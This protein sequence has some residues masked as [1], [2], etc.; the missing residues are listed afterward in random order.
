MK[1]YPPD[2]LEKTRESQNTLLL[3]EFDHL[4][5]NSLTASEIQSNIDEICMEVDTLESILLSEIKVH[6][7]FY[8]TVTVQTNLGPCDLIVYKTITLQIFPEESIPTKLTKIMS[9][10][11]ES[12][13]TDDT[14]IKEEKK[15][16]VKI[17]NITN[18]PSFTVKVMLPVS[19]PS[20]TPPIIELPA[21]DLFKKWE[22]VIMPEFQKIYDSEGSTCV[23]EWY[24]YLHCEFVAHF[25]ER[26]N[27]DSLSLTVTSKKSYEELQRKSR[28]TL[29][30]QLGRRAHCCMICFNHFY[31]SSLFVIANCEHFFCK[32]CLKFYC[33]NLISQGKVNEIKCPELKCG[34]T[35]SDSDLELIVS[36]EFYKK[37]FKFRFANEID[38]AE[39][40]TWCPEENCDGVARIVGGNLFG[41]C[42]K[43]Y[44]RFCLS[45]NHFYHSGRRCPVLSLGR[46]QF[47]KMTKKQQEEFLKEK[48][49][50]FYVLKHCK[51]CPNCHA[52]ISKISGC[53]KMVCRECGIYFCWKCLSIIK[54]YDHFNLN[55]DCWD[56]TDTDVGYLTNKEV[57]EVKETIDD[58][59]MENSVKCPH[60]DRVVE[61]T[62]SSNYLRCSACFTHLC[63]YCGNMAEKDHYEKYSCFSV[64]NLAKHRTVNIIAEEIG[65]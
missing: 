37:I 26:F 4:D 63:F 5:L 65:W 25:K 43:C 19:Y 46:N 8:P 40:K 24:N 58:R 16:K 28:D 62:N 13:G 53:N 36:D 12:E 31:G 30:Y 44:F 45:C 23:Y 59:D 7:D 6:D 15:V 11:S 52:R 56:F 54:G 57:D 49:N 1:E 29:Q 14:E 9:E 20:R 64:T 33:E 21:T 38:L 41:E 22:S 47:A 51:N 39:D 17:S 10:E 35:I 61:K 48:L 55:P 42:A 50:D 34:K 18:L 2:K 3:K 32:A 27:L 60:C